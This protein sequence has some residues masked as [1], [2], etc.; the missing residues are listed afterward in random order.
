MRAEV[1]IPRASWRL[2]DRVSLYSYIVPAAS[3]GTEY[4]QV[5]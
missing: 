4:S 5:S 2:T 3:G 1:L